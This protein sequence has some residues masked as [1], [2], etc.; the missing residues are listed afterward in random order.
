MGSDRSLHPQSNWR[1]V[2]TASMRT[3]LTL[4]IVVKDAY[5]D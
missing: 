1:K 4:T 2:W 5:K 3:L